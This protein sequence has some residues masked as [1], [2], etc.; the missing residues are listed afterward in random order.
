MD[1]RPAVTLDVSAFYP[2]SGGQPF[3][4][5]TLG[6]ARVLDVV[7][8]EDGR[9][10]HILD[11]DGEGLPAASTAI[12]IGRGGSIT[13]SSTPANTCCQRRSIGGGTLAPRA[14]TSA[15]RRPPSISRSLSLP[16]RLRVRKPKRTGS[17]G[18]TGRS[19]FAL[20]R[21]TRRDS[22]RCER[23]RSAKGRSGWWTSRAST[24][25]RAVARTSRGPVASASSR[26]VGPNGSRAA[27]E[28]NSSAAG[29]RSRAS[30]SS[31]TSW[32]APS[33]SCRSS[34]RICQT[35]S[36]GFSQTTR[37]SARSP[38]RSSRSSSLTRPVR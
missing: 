18:R 7:D 9:V 2:T 32:R 5:G 20:P 8:L 13:C 28:W 29:A 36:S 17:S 30:D 37:R 34:P 38:E 11:R 1:G 16:S 24:S 33:G 31:V 10:V 6:A 21:L 26:C 27:R 12:S 35:P 25:R 23:N 14:F 19:P 15:S 22:F 4:T 3:D